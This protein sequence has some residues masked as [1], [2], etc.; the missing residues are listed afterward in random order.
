MT[1]LQR[2][3]TGPCLTNLFEKNCLQPPHGLN[4]VPELLVGLSHGVPHEFGHHLR[5]VDDQRGGGVVGGY[6]NIPPPHKRSISPESYILWTG[7]MDM[8]HG[9]R[10]AAGWMSMQHQHEYGH[11]EWAWTCSMSM[12]MNM[13][14]C[15][16]E[17]DTQH[18]YGHAAWTWH[19]AWTWTWSMDMDKQH[20]HGHGHGH[21]AWTWTSS[22]DMDMQH[23]LLVGH[24]WAVLSGSLQL[25]HF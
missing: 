3:C 24:H 21:A 22:M 20:G 2:M 1:N 25:Y 6:V 14:T 11:V 10:H 16:I 19:T 5:D 17:M 18:L 15:S 12:D 7:S 23:G 4:T 13:Q 9:H 8:Q